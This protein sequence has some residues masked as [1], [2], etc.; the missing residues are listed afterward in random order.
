MRVLGSFERRGTYSHD[1]LHIFLVRLLSFPYDVARFLIHNCESAIVKNS[2]RNASKP[3]SPRVCEIQF[4]TF[5]FR[6]HCI[7]SFHREP[8]IQTFLRSLLIII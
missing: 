2:H 7:Q 3:R 1:W 5:E 6:N 4:G 8:I